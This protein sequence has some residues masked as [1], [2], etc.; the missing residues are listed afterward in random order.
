[1]N[2]LDWSAMMRAGMLDL[3]LKPAEF[4]ALTPAELLLMLGQTGVARPLGRSG[5]DDLMAAY[6][7]TMKGSNDDGSGR[8]R[9]A[10]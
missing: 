2:R 3:R 1:M 9:G 5:L 10:G 8:V 7:D 6:P 4:W